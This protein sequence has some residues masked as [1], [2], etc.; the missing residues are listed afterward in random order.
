MVEAKTYDDGNVHIIDFST[1]DYIYVHDSPSNKSTTLNIVPGGNLGYETRAYD[2]SYL[3]IDGGRINYLEAHDQCNI[4]INDGVL[5]K[6][7]AHNYTEVSLTNGLMYFVNLYGEAHMS[8]SGGQITE[9]NTYNGSSAT[10]SEGLIG[11]NVIAH[12]NSQINISGGEVW[13]NLYAY[14]NSRIFITG[15]VL[16]DPRGAISAGGGYQSID[17]SIITISGND[18]QIDGVNVGYGEIKNNSGND[19]L[20]GHLTGILSD[21]GYLN[22]R[23]EI[24]EQ[25]SIVLIPEPFTLSL[26]ALGGL[27]LLRKRRT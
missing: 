23:F 7:N 10:I 2:H 26:L 15:G 12:N 3:N 18:F 5:T 22:R 8:I 20:S 9:I 17:N 4:N 27:V 11:C 24:W 21:G 14:N 13:L 25:S 6:L 1:L 16:T 19:Y